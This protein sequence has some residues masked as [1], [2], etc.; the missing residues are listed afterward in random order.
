MGFYHWQHLIMFGL[1]GFCYGKRNARFL[2]TLTTCY[3]LWWLWTLQL[4]NN[5]FLGSWF[6]D[7]AILKWG[8]YLEKLSERLFLVLFGLLRTEKSFSKIFCKVL[9]VLKWTHLLNEIWFRVGFLCVYMKESIELRRECL[10]KDRLLGILEDWKL[11]W[12]GEF[13]IR[14]FCNGISNWVEKIIW[15]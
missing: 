7:Y 5:V 4:I 6:F 3:S 12:L 10:D 15:L 8:Y 1:K 11:I 9:F 13:R 14:C 2:L